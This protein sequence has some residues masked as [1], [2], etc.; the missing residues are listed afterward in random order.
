MRRCLFISYVF[1]PSGGAGV[2][3]VLK[4]VKYL[5][6]WGWEAVVV[7]PKNPSA[8]LKDDSYLGDLPR[9][10]KVQRLISLEP[11]LSGGDKDSS[12]KTSS[13]PGL[14]KRLALNLLFPDRHVIWLATA[15][16][17]TLAAARRHK[18]EAILVTGPP[19]STFI[20]GAAASRILGLPLVLDFRDDWSGFFTRGFEAHAGAGLWRTMVQKLEGALVAQAACVIG[21]TPEMTKRLALVHKGPADKYVWIPNGYDPDDFRFLPPETVEAASST[22]PP[23]RLRLLYAG[24]VFESH[25]LTDLWEGLKLLTAEQRGRISVEVVGRVVPGQVADPK[26]S[27]LE[28]TVLPYEPHQAI[29]RRMAAADVLVLTLADLP[30]LGRMVPAKLFEYMAARRPVLCLAP[31]GAAS[32]IVEA[33]G[34]GDVVRPGRPREVADLLT[35]WLR[36]PPAPSGPPPLFFSR[37]HLAGQLADALSQ[38]TSRNRTDVSQRSAP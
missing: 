25:P 17:G 18:A 9:D 2:Q 21:N 13:G 26:L 23:D 16:P 28:V 27:G 4:F 19:F 11:G 6:R 15:L 5:P 37:A 29:L 30:G 32:K 10:L 24:T 7:T 38:A 8:P 12:P 22:G 33:Y 36:N 14:V 34:A 1:P 20:L 31:L 3:R 35:R